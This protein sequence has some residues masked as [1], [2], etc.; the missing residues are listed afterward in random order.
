LKGNR[1]H[2]HFL[3]FAQIRSLSDNNSLKMK[4]NLLITLE[5]K[6]TRDQVLQ[7]NVNTA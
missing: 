3:F 5:W 2:V 4:R 7:K 6:A 1:N